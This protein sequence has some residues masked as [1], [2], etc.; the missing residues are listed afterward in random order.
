MAII[1][2]NTILANTDLFTNPH[3]EPNKHSIQ[4]RPAAHMRIRPDNTISQ[5]HFV[6]NHTVCADVA[7][8]QAAVGTQRAVR[9]NEAV[10]LN[11]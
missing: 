3:I 5:R 10:F 9:V 11:V 1:W 6:T 2:Y 4:I 8:N 7:I